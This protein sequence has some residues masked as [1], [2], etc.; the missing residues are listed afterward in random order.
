MKQN[1][2]TNKEATGRSRQ[3]LEENIKQ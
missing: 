3:D 2:K 1:E